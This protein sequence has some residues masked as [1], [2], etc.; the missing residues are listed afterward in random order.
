M[1]ASS[2]ND[3]VEVNGVGKQRFQAGKLP[4]ITIADCQGDLVIRPWMDLDVRA[5]GDFE[6][7]QL[8]EQL[9]FNATSDLVLTVPEVTA[10]RVTKGRGDVVIRNLSGGI[11]LDHV[12]GDLL[13]SNLGSVK[14]GKVDGD[15]VARNLSASLTVDQVTGD[16]VARNIDGDLVL[17]TVTGDAVAQ[18]ISGSL[19]LTNIMG[20]I[21]I[22]SVSGD[23][24]ITD[25]GR[26]AN[27]RNI[28]G[29][30]TARDISGDIRL[31]GG[32]GP[33]DHHLMAGG[34]FVL[35]WPVESPLLLDAQAG[36]IDNQLPLADLG[37]AGGTISGRLGDGKTRLELKVGG[38]LVLKPAQVVSKRWNMDGD[39]LFEFDFFADLASLGATI[40]SGV[41]EQVTRV[42]AELENSFGPDFIQQMAA[43]F[44]HKA[45]AAAEKARKAAERGSEKAAKAGQHAKAAPA[46]DKDGGG[47]QQPGSR[48]E[49]QLKILKMVENGVISPEE[50]NI[51]LQAL[52]GD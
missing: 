32:L 40:S 37:M 27:L 11:T 19:F 33:Y 47:A 1:F 38:R 12:S 26:D 21:N 44:S 29:R 4:L 30:C 17:T 8:D 42:T 24:A 5:E 2:L 39:D 49:A 45:E 46:K 9:I 6:V 48:Y 20:D 16:V 34:D 51:L 52:D 15:L 18:Y 50:A 23:L 10:V 25:G 36:S 28:G 35:R 22:R 31:L 43:Q 7:E 41:Q 13:L 14:I 3:V